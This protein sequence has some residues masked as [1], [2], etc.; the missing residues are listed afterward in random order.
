M[1]A[2]HLPR[3]ANPTI[4]SFLDHD[5]ISSKLWQLLG[6]EVSNIVS[7]KGLPMRQNLVGYWKLFASFARVG[8]ALSS[9]ED[10]LFHAGYFLP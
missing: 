7:V 4:I 3:K 2:T 6:L 8:N 1:G 10:I 5:N 9:G